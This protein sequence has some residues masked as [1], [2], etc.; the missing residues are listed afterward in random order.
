MSTASLGPSPTL[1]YRGDKECDAKGSGIRSHDVS[2]Q[3]VAWRVL[4]A[5]S[6]RLCPQ[7]LETT[8]RHK[9]RTKNNG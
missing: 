3:N 1:S 5:N 7:N 4:Q 6:N 2:Y 9:F 8:G